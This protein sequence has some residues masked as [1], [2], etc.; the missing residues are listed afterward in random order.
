MSLNNSDPT[1]RYYG[2]P[3]RMVDGVE[4]LDVRARPLPERYTFKRYRPREGERQ[5]LLATRFLRDPRLWWSLADVNDNLVPMPV[6]GQSMRV[7]V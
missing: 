1:S 5:D 4:E 6:P 3:T 2:V 7:P